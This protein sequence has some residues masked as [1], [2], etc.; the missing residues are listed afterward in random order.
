M[1]ASIAFSGGF[2]RHVGIVGANVCPDDGGCGGVAVQPGLAPGGT[3]NP[4]GVPRRAFGLSRD[5]FFTRLLGLPAAGLGCLTTSFPRCSALQ[6]T[7]HAE[8]DCVH[9]RCGRGIALKVT[10]CE[11]GGT[12]LVSI[13]FGEVGTQPGLL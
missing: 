1:A 12:D 4:C 2:V 5:A 13:V 3:A 9:K 11:D 8:S 10:D 7:K 6:P